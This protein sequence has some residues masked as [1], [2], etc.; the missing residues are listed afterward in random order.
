MQHVGQQPANCIPIG[1]VLPGVNQILIIAPT[2][3]H[4]AADMPGHQF[5][6]AGLIYPQQPSPVGEIADINKPLRA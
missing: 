4:K 3:T 5:D 6:V 2:A 1:F